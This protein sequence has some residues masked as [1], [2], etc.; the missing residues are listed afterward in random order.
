MV[1]GFQE[2]KNDSYDTS[3]GLV[4]ESHSVT[5]NVFSWSKQITG[6]A[7]TEEGKPTLLLDEVSSG[8]GTL[9]R[10]TRDRRDCCGYIW[11]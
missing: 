8:K 9:Q 4:Q 1:A 11:K 5:S 7:Q 2:G 10:G 3:L 6:S